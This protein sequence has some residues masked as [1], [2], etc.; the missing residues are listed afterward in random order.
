MHVYTHTIHVHGILTHRP[1]SQGWAPCVLLFCC[2]FVRFMGWGF[3]G[4]LSPPF[5]LFPSV[6]YTYTCTCNSMYMSY[7]MHTHTQCHIIYTCMYTCNIIILYLFP[8][9]TGSWMPLIVCAPPPSP[10]M[11]QTSPTVIPPPSSSTPHPLLLRGHT[12]QTSGEH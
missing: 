3:L 9:T 12:P 7:N 11:K 5:C 4:F 6:Q 10:L 1:S 8:L 2:L